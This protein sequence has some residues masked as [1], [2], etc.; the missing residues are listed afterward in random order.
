MDPRIMMNVKNYWRTLG[1]LIFCGAALAGCSE[2]TTSD[3]GRVCTYKATETANN[4]LGKD[5][6]FIVKEERGNTIFIYQSL[7]SV[8]IAEN[9]QLNAK[10]EL[11]F[12]NTD[13]DTA[14][15]ILLQNKKY[16]T[17]LIG[18]EKSKGFE[19]VNEL[20]TCDS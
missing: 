1:M 18:E 13:L 12:A 15:V 4:I 10:R 20:L 14:R 9:I 3:V 16:F 7:P 17:Q 2:A 19:A 8:P 5:A 11:I 6:E